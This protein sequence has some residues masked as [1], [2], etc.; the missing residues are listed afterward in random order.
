VT[1][2]LLAP[3]EPLVR[4]RGR[5]IWIIISIVRWRDWSA[6]LHLTPLPFSA[7]LDPR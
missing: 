1:V 7:G 3:W 2:T 4:E 6:F 5:Q